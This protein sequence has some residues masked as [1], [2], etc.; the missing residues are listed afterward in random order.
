MRTANDANGHEMLSSS[1]NHVPDLDP[2]E[3]QQVCSIVQLGCPR[4]TA[5]KQVGCTISSIRFAAQGDPQFAA[6]LQ[7]AEAQNE[8]S[9]MKNVF[10]S[11]QEPKNWR[12]SVWALERM[13]PERYLRRAPETIPIDQLVRLVDVMVRL[14][15]EEVNDPECRE[16]I[17]RRVADIVS[18]LQQET[19]FQTSVTHE[20]PSDE[21]LFGEGDQPPSE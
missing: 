4:A 7:R 3:K 14:I 11:A 20:P 17:V 19:G 9:L 8:L 1:Q 18:N 2:I 16:R 12:A 13:Y 10:V 21:N 6:E 5:A 15:A